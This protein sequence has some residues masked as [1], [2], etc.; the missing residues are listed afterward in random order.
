ML[1]KKFQENWSF[2]EVSTFPTKL[3]IYICAE[4]Q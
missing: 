3:D 1:R 2:F 4:L